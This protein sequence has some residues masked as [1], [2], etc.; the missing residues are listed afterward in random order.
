MSEKMREEF[1]EWLIANT[2]FDTQRTAFAMTKEEDQQYMC[3]RTNLAWLAW[4]A[5]RAALVVELPHAVHINI[6]E[7]MV[8]L[9]DDVIDSLESSGV[10]CK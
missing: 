1:E 5:S 10:K 7:R 9:E 4:Q 3:H 8:L 6:S 2:E